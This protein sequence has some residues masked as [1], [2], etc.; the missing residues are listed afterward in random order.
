MILN[1]LEIVGNNIKYYR[2]QKNLSQETL[3]EKC[4]LHRTYISDIERYRRNVSLTNI[5]K[6]AEALDV[7][8]YKLLIPTNSEVM[9]S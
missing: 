1:I 8:P 6:I 3:A 2:N 4:E 5:Q 7:A 9:K